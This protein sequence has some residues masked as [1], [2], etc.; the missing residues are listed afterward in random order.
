MNKHYQ[1]RKFSLET[2]RITFSPLPKLLK[3]PRYSKIHIT[4]VTCF[5]I[6]T[7]HWLT[8][9]VESPNSRIWSVVTV[10]L[11]INIVFL[12]SQ[13]TVGRQYDE[14]TPWVG[15]KL[16][17]AEQKDV[18]EPPECHHILTSCH[19]PAVNDYSLFSHWCHKCVLLWFFYC[20]LYICAL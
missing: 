15:N 9:V 16:K 14:I 20:C 3:V 2:Y 17:I 13:M 11:I 19:H 4:I 5:E 18:A 12:C 7:W 6:I 8:G 1:K 10:K